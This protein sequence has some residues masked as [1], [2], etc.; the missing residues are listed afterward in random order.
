MLK[1]L[2]DNL[3]KLI[4]QYLHASFVNAIGESA[5]KSTE[6]YS[7]IQLDESEDIYLVKDSYVTD[8]K[9]DIEFYLVRTQVLLESP[10]IQKHFDGKE[11]P[12]SAAAS[13]DGLIL[14]RGGEVN[15][16]RIGVRLAEL[17]AAP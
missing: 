12:V 6:D 1:L 2:S 10:S 5:Q 7:L 3:D 15:Y 17:L 9:T 11:I 14:W 13:V 4:L 8:T 16:S